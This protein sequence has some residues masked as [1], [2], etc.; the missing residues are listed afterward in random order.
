MSSIDSD[1][2]SVKLDLMQSRL[3]L[4]Q[5]LQNIRTHLD[6]LEMTQQLSNC[7]N[8]SQQQSPTRENA[9]SIYNGMGIMEHVLNF[10]G[11]IG[12]DFSTFVQTFLDY[13]EAYGWNDQRKLDIFPALL[14]GWPREALREAEANVLHQK[15]TSF[16]QLLTYLGPLVQPALQ[17]RIAFIRLNNKRQGQAECVSQFAYELGFLVKSAFPDTSLDT[18]QALLKSY[19]IDGLRPEIGKSVTLFDL[20]SF[21]KLVILRLTLKRNSNYMVVQKPQQF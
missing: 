7:S 2:L 16:E 8:N 11:T 19:F 12:E 5:S 13:S 17:D 21:W 15:F 18:Q 14:K 10:S 20:P 9:S 6:Y 1:Q 4:L 3:R